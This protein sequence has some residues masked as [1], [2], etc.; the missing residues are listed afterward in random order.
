MEG[1]KNNLL[2]RW[3][4]VPV[5]CRCVGD[6]SHEMSGEASVQASG[7]LL[8]DHELERL[9]EPSVLWL[10]HPVG[11]RLTETRAQ[12]L[13]RVGDESGK[14]LCSSCGSE[15]AGPLSELAS[16]FADAHLLKA[17]VH[18]PLDD[19]LADSEHARRQ[20]LVQPTDTLRADDEPQAGPRVRELGR[21]DSVGDRGRDRVGRER[22]RRR[23]EAH[24][25]RWRLGGRGEG[26]GR[27]DMAGGRGGGDLLLVRL[28]ELQ[29]RLDDP[30]WVRHS[31]SGDT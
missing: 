25:G 9:H 24:E 23:S 11:D 21:L 29:T 4:D 30:D 7:A 19:P 26:G 1:V 22:G 31:T 28:S 16:L 10:E 12:D 8:G 18:G 6:D 2:N 27:E 20:A 17:L 13:V 3:K 5:H 15:H 14:Q